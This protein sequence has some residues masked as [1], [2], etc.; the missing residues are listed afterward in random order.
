MKNELKKQYEGVFEGWK[1]DLALGRIK[2]M[3]FPES[4]WPDL[5]QELA[6]VMLD[7]R[8]DPAKVN[9]AAE[10]TVFYEVI[11]RTLLHQMRTRCRDAA[12]LKRYARE[13]GVRADGTGD[14]PCCHLS[15]PT[16][17]DV[18]QVCE[19][20]SEFDQKVCRGIAM[21]KNRAEIAR[22]LECDWG[23]VNK[24]IRRIRRIFA[25]AGLKGW[26]GQGAGR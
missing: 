18:V 24:A 16:D 13:M 21:G 7:F 9:G 14:E 11:S 25:E 8:C 19:G 1:V 3:G 10:Q 2:A 20:L 4:D 5:M 17:M 6:I 22:K 12:K 23:T 26:M 15:A